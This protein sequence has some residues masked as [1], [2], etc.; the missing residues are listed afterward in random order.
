MRKIFV[1]PMVVCLFVLLHACED[2]WFIEP[3]ENNL[4]LK[5]NLSDY[6]LYQIPLAELTPDTNAFVYELN[7]A[8][9]TDYASKQRIIKL[10]KGQKLDVR[11][12]SAIDFPDGTIIA[13]TFFYPEN[14]QPNNQTRKILETRLLILEKGQWNVGVY[15]WNDSQTEAYLIENGAEVRMEQ[16]LPNGK[17]E[18]FTYVIPSNS[19]CTT[20]HNKNS[21]VNPIGPKVSNLNVPH[22]EGSNNSQIQS[23]INKGY[24][25]GSSLDELPKLP[26]WDNPNHLLSP[27]ARA[28]LDVN[29]AHCHNPAGVA[30]EWSL[31]LRYSTPYNQTGIQPLRY[32]I[33]ERMESDWEDEVMP[34]I[35]TTL[36]HEEGIELIKAYIN[37]L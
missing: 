28:Y 21:K 18:R 31:D 27:R 23:W 30:S 35:G 22:W 26:Q 25:N 33:P 16:I 11:N 32:H 8:L 3:I 5:Y 1:T 13:K 36:K 17:A 9:F 2:E 19:D 29:C 37:Q 24:L 10:P 7:T 15:K 14:Q 34:K 20:C 4:V 12:K 6:D